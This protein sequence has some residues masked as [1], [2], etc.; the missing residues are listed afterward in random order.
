MSLGFQCLKIT[1]VPTLEYDEFRPTFAE[2]CVASEA[3]L[4]ERPLD[5]SLDC[6]TTTADFLYDFKIGYMMILT[7]ETRH[8]HLLHQL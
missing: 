8:S 5:P 6:G 7:F 4:W 3:N 1:V 2:C